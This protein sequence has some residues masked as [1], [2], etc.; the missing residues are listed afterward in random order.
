MAQVGPSDHDRPLPHNDGSETPVENPRDAEPATQTA[1]SS[2]ESSL[3]TSKPSPAKK[4]EGVATETSDMGDHTIDSAQNPSVATG[5]SPVDI[6]KTLLPAPPSSSDIPPPPPPPPMPLPPPNPPTSPFSSR[7]SITL[8][9]SAAAVK[10]SNPTT[11]ASAQPSLDN[12]LKT[13]SNTSLESTDNPTAPPDSNLDILVTQTSKTLPNPTHD[14]VVQ[15][16]DPSPDPNNN[17]PVQS[18]PAVTGP[19]VTEGSKSSP[20]EDAASHEES[21]ATEEPNSSMLPARQPAPI[22]DVDKL[23]SVTRR[24]TDSSKKRKAPDGDSSETDGPDDDSPRP[25]KRRSTGTPSDLYPAFQGNPGTDTSDHA[26]VKEEPLNTDMEDAHGNLSEAAK[27]EESL[28]PSESPTKD[29]LPSPE[30][31]PESEKETVHSLSKP[32]VENIQDESGGITVGGASAEESSYVE[33]N[34]DG[35]PKEALTKYV[36]PP[37]RPLPKNLPKVA[38]NRPENARV[39]IGNLAS[40]YTDIF[41]I[42]KVFHKYGTLIE[43]PV[44]RRSFGF[45]QYSSAEAAKAAVDGEQ[46]RM[47]GGIGI[48]LSI[49]DNREVRKGT[50]IMN[51]TPFQH[52]RL[53]TSASNRGSRREREGSSTFTS[54]K[55]RRSASPQGPPRKGG[56]HPPQF[57]RQRPEPRNGIYLRILCMSPTAKAYARHCENTFSN[58][59]GLRADV[60]HIIAAGLGEALGRAM[61]DSIPYVMVVASK[62][63]E[64]GTCTIRTLEKTGYEKSGRGNGVIPLREA[65]EVCLI[66]RGILM[67]NSASQNMAGN[68]MG[69][70]GH[71][72]G[73]HRGGGPG[74]QMYMGRGAAPGTAQW[75]QGAGVVGEPGEMKPSWMNDSR[76]PHVP[77]VRMPGI[78]GGGMGM[79]G[80]GV[81]GSGNSGMVSGGVQGGYGRMDSGRAM[82]YGQGGLGMNPN[83]GPIGLG[84]PNVQEMVGSNVRN[85]AYDGA[86]AMGI[87]FGSAMGSAGMDYGRNLGAVP[88]SMGIGSGAQGGA[89]YGERYGG[90]GGNAR[91]GGYG[92]NRESE[93]DPASVNG[94]MRNGG[95]GDWGRDQGDMGGGDMYGAGAIMQGAAANRGPDV[96]MYGMGM[97]GQGYR[98]S[99]GGYGAGVGPRY[100]NNGGA[101]QMDNNQGGGMYAGGMGGEMGNVP[102]YDSRRMYGYEGYDN[103]MGGYRGNDMGMGQ[104]RLDQTQVQRQDAQRYTSGQPG[105]GALAHGQLGMYG[106]PSGRYEAMG[107]MDMY[108]NREGAGGNTNTGLPGSGY[109]GGRNNDTRR[110]GGRN[111]GANGGASAGSGG[112]GTVDIDNLKL[113]NLINAFTQKQQA[114]GHGPQTHQRQ[115]QTHAHGGRLGQQTNDHQV[116]AHEGEFRRGRDTTAVGSGTSAGMGA[117]AGTRLMPGGVSQILANPAVQQA[118]QN[119]GGAGRVAAGF[120]ASGMPAGMWQRQQQQQSQQTQQPQQHQQQT[121][122]IRGPGSARAQRPGVSNPSGP[123]RESQLGHMAPN[124]G[125]YR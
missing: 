98:S 112:G 119:I 25:L 58:M 5:P 89:G 9:K 17:D 115:A 53:G 74:G 37:E 59:T 66:E 65:V 23:P 85:D 54:R 81:G 28:A 35:S 42:I 27:T 2:A 49:A 108:A 15:S 44:L 21:L 87:P 114:Q 4:D 32:A 36:L 16:A 18:K 103:S 69:S 100:E 104:G 22:D 93:Y 48:D 41:E 109:I 110:M 78:P 57:R 50:H 96:G 125:Y 45:V 86:N 124:Q 105:S 76:G 90:H 24:P 19:F 120:N 64:D 56:V 8:K 6:E 82:G 67:P 91:P 20:P 39:F 102:G 60:L 116:Q 70:S 13:K 33:V 62:D 101:S 11:M 46:G 118:L 117:S 51:N 7:R 123:H 38:K 122:T 83:V 92:G 88:F 61:R 12:D 111:G 40:E 73:G 95:Y 68:A 26:T 106:D 77:N 3:P 63:V 113:S 31:V 94:P 71:G 1:L 72:L 107:G 79:G 99:G 52:P 34:S 10:A 14:S 43:E 30:S 80:M 97:G 84:G 47:I 75:L 121:T 55:R 29:K